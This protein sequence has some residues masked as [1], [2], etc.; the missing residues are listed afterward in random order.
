[1]KLILALLLAAAPGGLSL[2]PS[3]KGI[4]PV[5]FDLE[6]TFEERVQEA[7][8]AFVDPTVTG[9]RFGQDGC[10]TSA[11]DLEMVHLD[12]FA[13]MADAL[14]ELGKRGL[15]PATADELVAFA[16]TYRAFPRSYPVVA[17]GTVWKSR[18]VFAAPYQGEI[19]LDIE[20]ARVEWTLNARFL[21]ARERK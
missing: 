3:G 11:A 4:Y 12:R 1:M 13:T 21:A 7:K 17:F 10:G 16:S 14:Q 8:F 9:G 18:V 20:D 5:E 2:A 19:K 6:K 15:R